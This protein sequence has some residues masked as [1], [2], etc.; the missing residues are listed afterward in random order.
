MVGVGI[1]PTRLQDLD[2][3]ALAIPPD[4]QNRDFRPKTR[5]ASSL[6]LTPKQKPPYLHGSLYTPNIALMLSM[7]KGLG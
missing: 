4:R 6:T 7:S 2:L 1:E 5:V 3:V